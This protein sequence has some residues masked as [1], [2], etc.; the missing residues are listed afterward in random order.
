MVV[1]VTSS[2]RQAYEP[3][4]DIPQIETASM[5]AVDAD[6]T[7]RNI[8]SSTRYALE[9]FK[10]LKQPGAY[11]SPLTGVVR[12]QL[13][14]FGITHVSIREIVKVAVRRDLYPLLGDAL[15]LAR[16]QV[17]KIFIIAILLDSPVTGFKQYIRN[18]VK[19]EYLDFLLQKEEQAENARFAEFLTQ[20]LPA[21]I[22]KMRRPAFLGKSETFVSKYALRVLEFDW[23][24]PL[25][26]N[27]PWFK[28]TKRNNNVQNYI[29][30]YF[31]FA[32]PGRSAKEIKDPKLRRF[33]YRWHKEY[34]H[35]SQYTHVRV[36]KLQFADI[37]KHKDLAFQAGIKD[38]AMRSAAEAINVSYTAVASAC[39]LVLSKVSNTYGAQKELIE[40]WDELIHYSLLSKALWHMY[41]ADLLTPPA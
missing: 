37:P 30:N 23:N 9:D 38:F 18:K 32:T 1:K 31:E 26:K 25:A 24:N 33:L 17:E 36:G 8:I 16:E 13:R 29:R 27:P 19:T 39:A 14:M 2:P 10:N 15:S 28:G 4:A 3:V 12:D 34:T 5:D 6:G 11:N 20:T 41:V 7:M 40:F 35:L 21:R 22:E